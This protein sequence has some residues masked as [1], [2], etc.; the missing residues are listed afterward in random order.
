M[1]SSYLLAHAERAAAQMHDN[2]KRICEIRKNPLDTQSISCIMKN[3]L[4]SPTRWCS[5]SIA[6]LKGKSVQIRRGPATVC[7]RKAQ[8]V[9]EAHAALGRR[10][11][12]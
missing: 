2:K 7:E 4:H 12:H 11:N 9:T 3:E 8:H 10:A 5:A 6:E 1:C